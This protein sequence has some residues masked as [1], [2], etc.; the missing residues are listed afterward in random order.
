MDWWKH[1]GYIHIFMMTFNFPQFQN[2]FSTVTVKEVLLV[3][4]GDFTWFDIWS[5]FDTEY[6]VEKA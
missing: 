1:S 5:Q 2:A 6:Q 3:P 4:K